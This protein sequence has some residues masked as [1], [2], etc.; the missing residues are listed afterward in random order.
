MYATSHFFIGESCLLINKK[1]ADIKSNGRKNCKF[2]GVGSR[3]YKYK[4]TP[5]GGS[6]ICN[7]K[8]K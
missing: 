5:R 3:K 8:K 4:E 7:D 2:K 6:K 1:Y